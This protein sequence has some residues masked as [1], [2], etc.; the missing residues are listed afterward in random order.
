V[1][2]REKSGQLGMF[3]GD[4]MVASKALF[5][6]LYCIRGVTKV[7]DC[8]I[9]ADNTLDLS[10]CYMLL[11]A[12]LLA[13]FLWSFMSWSSMGDSE[14]MF[15]YRSSYEDAHLGGRVAGGRSVWGC[16]NPFRRDM[17]QRAPFIALRGLVAS[18]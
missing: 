10:S 16:Q 15:A 4:V 13:N 18:R 11:G 5:G 2:W 7:V 3:V 9:L 1:A 8:G 17:K 6:L 12:G 14:D